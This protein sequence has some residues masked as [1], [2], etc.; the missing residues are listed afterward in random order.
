MQLKIVL[1][2]LLGGRNQN[3][4]KQANSFCEEPQDPSPTIQPNINVVTRGGKKNG[5]DIGTLDQPSIIGLTSLMKSYHLN[6]HKEYYRDV[7][8]LFQ[9]LISS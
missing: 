7:V 2:L 8:E 5:D 1:N 9:L 3:Q 6:Q 4:A